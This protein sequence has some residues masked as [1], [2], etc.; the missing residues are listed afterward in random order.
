[1]TCPRCAGLMVSVG[2]IDWESTYLEC[3]AHK[4]VAC[5]HVT[6]AVIEHHHE[7]CPAQNSLPRPIMAYLPISHVD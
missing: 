1:M 4:C 3:P 7:Q 2:L 6:D 5:G